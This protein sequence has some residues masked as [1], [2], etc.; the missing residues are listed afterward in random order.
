MC[1]RLYSSLSLPDHT[2][3]IMPKVSP[4]MTAGRLVEWKKRE[5]DAINEG[6]DLADVESDKATM[7]IEA[8]D[9]A[10]V[11]RIFVPDD[12]PDIPL[13]KLL[14]ILVEEQ[15]DIAAFQSYTLSAED[16]IASSQTASQSAESEAKTEGQAQPMK[17]ANETHNQQEYNGPIGPAVLRLLN[18]NKTINLSAVRPTGPKGRILKGD[19]LA[20]IESGAAFTTPASSPSSPSS[21]PPTA[22]STSTSTTPT[23]TPTPTTTTS[24]ST[25][26]STST[27]ALYTDEPVSS[28]R[29]AIA[30]RLTKTA[31]S[32]EYQSVRSDMRHATLL[33]SELKKRGVQ[34]SMNDI[35]LKATAIA[36]SRV[37]S[38][39]PS[40]HSTLS[41]GIDVSF[42]VAV[43][44]GLLTPIVRGADR[45]GLS[46]IAKRTIDLAARAKDGALEPHEYEGGSFT[47]SNLGMMGVANFS[48]IINPPQ[49]AIL[50]V[51]APLK[52]LDVQKDVED[53]EE[54]ETL[55]ERVHS[56]ATLSYDIASV[57]KDCGS[58]MLHEFSACMENPSDMML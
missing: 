56:V 46:E 6:D 30:S 33:R 26:T 29:R 50:A 19:V 37:P 7:P 23:P 44:G 45:L 36:L 25:S 16:A 35:I 38:L 22:T 51:G 20:A 42:A 43:P 40:T 34:V 5:G 1:R 55:V 11:A 17:D 10:Y 58:K 52:T 3:V 12:T 13:G 48:A 2:R 8:R 4:T 39:L 28:M 9:D 47:V 21:Q 32:H 14:A 41:N 49:R 57:D 15:S 31:V 27:A 18:Q 53:G 24:T 54:I